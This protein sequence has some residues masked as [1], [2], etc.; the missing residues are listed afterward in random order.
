M[1]TSIALGRSSFLILFRL[2]SPGEP[3][4]KESSNAG[5]LKTF[6][7]VL[8]LPAPP[9]IDSFLGVS[10]SVEYASKFGFEIRH[11]GCIFSCSNK[12]WSNS[13]ELANNCS[14][15]RPC[16]CLGRTLDPSCAPTVKIFMVTLAELAAESTESTPPRLPYFLPKACLV[17]SKGLSKKFMDSATQVRP[18]QAAACLR[19][20]ASL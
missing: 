8:L 19:F 17:G 10:V 3:E 9:A 7:S 18:A 15:T 6:P 20:S 2:L 13:I 5:N 12:F 14:G 16:E 4:L 1:D 11:L